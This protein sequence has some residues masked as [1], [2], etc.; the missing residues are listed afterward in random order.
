MI[1]IETTSSL[2]N[3]QIPCQPVAYAQLK[4]FLQLK[5]LSRQAYKLNSLSG[6][7]LFSSLNTFVDQFN[8]LI[9]VRSTPSVLG[10]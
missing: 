1:N 10:F 6:F 2:Y 8:Q 9:H 5:E 3:Q 7:P 4:Q